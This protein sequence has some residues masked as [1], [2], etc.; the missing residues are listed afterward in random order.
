VTGPYV[1]K[2]NIAMLGGG[3]TVLDSSGPR[4]KGPGGQ[5]VIQNGNSWIIAF[6]SYD[7]NNNG[8]P[9]LQIS[10]LFWDFDNW[11]TFTGPAFVV[12][13]VAG[14]A[15]AS[16][17]TDGTGSAA[18][19]NLPADV[20]TDSAGNIYVADTYNNSVRKITAAGVVTTFASGFNHPSGIVV[21]SA[22]N[23]YVADTNNNSIRKITSAGVVSTIA[24]GFNGPS[25]IAVDSSG[26]LY[27][28]D[29]LDHTIRGVTSTGA[30]SII[31]GTPG[32]SGSANGIGTAARFQGPQGLALDGSGN[33][34]VADTNNDT[35]RRI[36]LASGTVT[37]VAG[38]VGANGSADGTGSQAQFYFPSG[39]ATDTAGN[40]YIADTDNHTIRRMA[41][42]GG[43]TT[44]A[45]Q[46]GTGGSAD[47]IDGATRFNFP[48]GLAV[49]NS[50]GV[51]IADTDN[52]AI[53]LGAFATGPGITTQPQSQTV[54]AGA[55]VQFSVTAS[56]RPAPTY[57]WNFNGTAIS[58]ATGSSYSLASAQAANAGNYTVT[59]T[60]AVGSVTSSQAALTVNPAA[61]GGSGGGSGGGG[62]GGGG[63]LGLWFVSG[64]ALLGLARTALLRSGEGRGS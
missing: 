14:Q 23:T 18:R 27:V 30:A 59:V 41:V 25:G 28:A 58:G 50:G 6:H 33:L 17:G 36:V 52:H 2:G 20:A 31:A 61:P 35:I 54:M 42:S 12:S 7:A 34:Y 19:F 47:G 56:G 53:R 49:D 26:N 39:L 60:N 37:T 46:V 21:D 1:D 55:S 11:P 10:D 15:G 5:S 57:Q 44:I 32:V 22:G 16:G 9:T 64:L 38:Q 51:Y 4:W 29:T 40:L 45:G 62:G 8:A 63:A 48:T 13:T 3:G 43:V 24:T